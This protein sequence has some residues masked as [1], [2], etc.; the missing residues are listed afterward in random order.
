M[1]NTR[2]FGPGAAAQVAA[3]LALL[4]TFST[5]VK[6]G[7]HVADDVKR[8]PAYNT[9]HVAGPH[10]PYYLDQPVRSFALP[11]ILREASAV[12]HVDG[13]RVA[14]VQDEKGIVFFYSLAEGRLGSEIHFAGNGDYEGLVVLETEAW[15]LRSDGTLFRIGTL[16]AADPV[17]A[18]FDTF[19]Q[20]EDDTE[21]LAYDTAGNQLL[22]GLKEPPRLAGRRQK[23]KRAV[24]AFPLDGRSMSAAPFLLLDMQDLKRVYANQLPGAGS[25]AFDPR[26]VEDF[27]P[28]D[29]A[30]HP[31]TGHIYHIAASGQLL[32]VSDRQGLI[33]FVRELPEQDFR[34]PEGISFD[35]RGNMFIVSEGGAG[36]ATLSE[37]QYEPVARKAGAAGPTMKFGLLPGS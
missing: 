34:Q 11:A 28:A 27:M 36:S 5:G 25:A 7:R 10:F 32:V 4:I 31:V 35:R 30:I 6:V 8:N 2:F 1:Q 17:P 26:Q 24:F 29:L 21:G 22:I 33:H 15:V 16:T 19:L 20:S 18:V 13:R 12:S 14:M 3:A 37:F 23:D 9:E